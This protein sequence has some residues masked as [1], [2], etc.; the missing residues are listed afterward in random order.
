LSNVS[1]VDSKDL[2]YVINEIET[3]VW[4]LH[5]ADTSM[6][7]EGVIDL[8]WPDANILI[9]GNRMTYRE[10]SEGSRKFMK[11]LTHFH[12]EW[13]DLQ[14]LPVS[15]NAAISSYIFTDSIV[16]NQGII[17]QAKGPNTFIWQKRN[18]E[19]KIIFGDADHYPRE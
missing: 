15:E 8:L 11:E 1:E 12:A 17:S 2:S 10:L 7:A 16:N 14:I 13:N 18:D 19:W 9:D 6:N 3:V 4:A 5:A